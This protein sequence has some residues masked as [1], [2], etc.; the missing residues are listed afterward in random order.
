LARTWTSLGDVYFE[1]GR[2]PDATDAYNTA[3]SADAFLTDIRA[4]TQMLI[5]S[6][7]SA[8]KFDDARR[9]CIGARARFPEDL[10]FKECEL[11][12]LGWAGK[13]RTDV[14]DAW[15]KLS[16]IEREDSAGVLSFNRTFRRMMVAAVI[17]RSGL[18]DS[19]R[20]VI[21]QA[22][23]NGGDEE[24]ALAAEAYVHVLL[25]EKDA[26]I[27]LLSRL[28]ATTPQVRAR[29]AR[30]PWFRDLRNEPAFRDLFSGSV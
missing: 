25:G 23:R 29:I 21:A 14:V 18:Q 4:V 8:G 27:K 7:L 10:R 13:S 20:T 11:V 19:A 5:F 17:A 30:S 6:N 9:W 3:Y 16:V 22:L 12:L 15:R 2:Y 24:P 1:Q 26:A 28:V